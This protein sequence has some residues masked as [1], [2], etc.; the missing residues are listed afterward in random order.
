MKLPALLRVSEIFRETVSTLIRLRD[1]DYNLHGLVLYLLS[2]EITAY[3]DTLRPA[4]ANEV[5]G[6]LNSR[7]RLCPQT[8]LQDLS[9]ADEVEE[10]SDSPLGNPLPCFNTCDREITPLGRAQSYGVLRSN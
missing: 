4:Y 10:S 3:V 9:S 1:M 5:T 8:P 2:N 7:P 6:Q